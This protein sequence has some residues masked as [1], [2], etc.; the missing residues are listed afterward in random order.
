MNSIAHWL[1][2][3]TYDDKLTPRDHFLT[4]LLTLGEGYLNFHHQFPMDYRNAVKW[5]QYDPTKWFIATMARLGLAKDLRVFPDNEI[6]KGELT[7]SLKRLKRVQ[8]GL[9]WPRK[10]TELPIIDWKT[11][12]CFSPDTLPLRKCYLLSDPSPDFSTL[13]LFLFFI[14]RSAAIHKRMKER[15]GTIHSKFIYAK[16]DPNSLIFLRGSAP[17]GDA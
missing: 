12:T 7:M 15:V 16:V 13:P 8:D 1:G 17:L 6:R 11:C 9:V 4:A 3:T 5:Y 10:S 2:E 14:S